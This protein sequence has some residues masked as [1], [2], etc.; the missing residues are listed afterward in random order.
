VRLVP[1][2]QRLGDLGQ[3]FVEL[4]AAGRALSAGM[5]PTTPDVHCAITSLGLLMMNSG[6]P[7]TGNFRRLQNG[8]GNLDMGGFRQDEAPHRDTNNAIL[9]VK[10]LLGRP[11]SAESSTGASS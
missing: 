1:R 5:E 9:E 7:M 2:G 11:S 8:G 6:E 10:K 4:R 3:P